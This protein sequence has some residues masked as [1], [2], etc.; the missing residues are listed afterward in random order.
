[1]GFGGV[2][3]LGASVLL[4]ILI[5]V[6]LTFVPHN[7][8]ANTMLCFSETEKPLSDTIKVA[9]TLRYLKTNIAFV[10]AY[11]SFHEK[12]RS[13]NEISIGLDGIFKLEGMGRHLMLGSFN[14][15][16]LCGGVNEDYIDGG[17]GN[18]EIVGRTLGDELV[19]FEGSDLISS[20]ADKNTD[21]DGY[22]DKIDCGPGE[23]EAWINTSTDGDMAVNCE[24]LH[25]S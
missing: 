14:N 8:Q 2:F 1:M 16:V 7:A 18:D 13:A 3:F 9:D 6:F 12:L 4:L 11:D 20:N 23:D 15:D 19:G 21:P 5:L 17:S 22:K 25:T 10:G 24:I